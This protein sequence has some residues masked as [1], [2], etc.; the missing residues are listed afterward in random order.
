M[1]D[2]LLPERTTVEPGYSEELQEALRE[3]GHRVA[4]ASGRESAVQGVRVWGHLRDGEEGEG[5]VLK[6]KDGG[7]MEAVG[8]PRQAG[9]GGVGV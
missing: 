1:H 7:W 8:E 3:R 9:S 4:W 2:Q 5:E 6:M